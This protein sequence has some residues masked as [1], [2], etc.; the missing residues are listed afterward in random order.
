V[1][2]S[3]LASRISRPIK[4]LKAFQK[5]NLAP[6]ERREINIVIEPQALS[7]YDPANPGWIA[8]PG[9]FELLIGASSRDIRL[10]TTISLKDSA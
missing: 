7:Y 8:E 1:Y 9:E 5:V 3:D 10:S 6:G 2:V 4:E